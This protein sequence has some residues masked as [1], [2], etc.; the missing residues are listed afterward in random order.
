L[1]CG[2]EVN[3][4]NDGILAVLDGTRACVLRPAQ[5]F[6]AWQGVLT[7]CY[8]GLPPALADAKA[9]LAARYPHLPKEN[10]GSMWPKTTVA[11]LREGKRLS[12][13]QLATL[14]RVCA[15]V[16]KRLESDEQA[17]VEVESL[18]A[19]AYSCRSLERRLFMSTLPLR[20]P[21]DRQQPREDDA[22]RARRVL[23]EPLEEGY[24]FQASKDGNREAHYRGE[25]AGMTLVSFLPR[26][27]AR[28][29]ELRAAV[30]EALPGMYAFFEQASLHVTLRALS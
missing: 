17:A 24:W 22:E 21:V 23:A 13:E 29:A 28:L 9:H 15:E 27:P 2:E 7:L 3:L 8:T 12:P 18:S 30:E 4:A 5:Y 19:T 26:A 25:A 20:G 1:R 11:C 14:L 6:P 10:P 16:S